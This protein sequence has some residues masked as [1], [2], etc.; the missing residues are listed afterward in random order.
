[1]DYD[2]DRIAP[3]QLGRLRCEGRDYLLMPVTLIEDN[4]R[5]VRV[6]ILRL[7]LDSKGQP[8]GMGLG[9]FFAWWMCSMFDQELFRFPLVVTARTLAWSSLVVIIAAAVSG[10]IVRRN[11]DHLD[12]VAVLKQ[13]E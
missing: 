9:N 1:M 5:R 3:L 4:G 12:L 8:L 10:L 6:T 11:L 2:P 7:S 13:R